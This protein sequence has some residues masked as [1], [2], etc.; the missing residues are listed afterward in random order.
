ME[1]KWCET[2]ASYDTINPAT[3]HL[4]Y[5]CDHCGNT[6]YINICDVHYNEWV[7]RIFHRTWG[8]IHCGVCGDGSEHSYIAVFPGKRQ[9]EEYIS[10]K[11]TAFHLK[12]G[13]LIYESVL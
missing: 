3:C 2:R 12:P 5:I 10:G 11:A 1:C 8:G 13:E 9:Q 6:G 7:D 4:S